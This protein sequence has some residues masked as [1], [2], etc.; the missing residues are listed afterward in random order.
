MKFGDGIQNISGATISA[1]NIT[2]GIQKTT[3]QMNYLKNQGKI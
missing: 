1:R 3:I 2:S